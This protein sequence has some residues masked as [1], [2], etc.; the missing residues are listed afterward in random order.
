M[1]EQEPIV[2]LP[3]KAGN[4]RFPHTYS[5]HVGLYILRGSQFGQSEG[6][7]MPP[8]PHP[9][10]RVSFWSNGLLSLLQPAR[11]SEWKSTKCANLSIPFLHA[12]SQ[13]SIAITEVVLYLGCTI[14]YTHSCSCWINNFNCEKEASGNVLSESNAIL[15]FVNTRLQDKSK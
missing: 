3:C 6:P 8:P 12:S 11:A 14:I 1:T 2:Y 7:F 10:G 15:S 13:G 4:G 9:T 5:V